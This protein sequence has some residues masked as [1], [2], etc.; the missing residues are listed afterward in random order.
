M[1]SQQRSAIRERKEPQKNTRSFSFKRRKT[2]NK[3]LFPIHSDAASAASLASSMA[4]CRDDCRVVEKLGAVQ[5]SPGLVVGNA[6]VCPRIQQELQAL[7]E[8]MVSGRHARGD[9]VA[10][11]GLVDI[12]SSGSESCHSCSKALAAGEYELGGDAGSG[13]VHVAASGNQSRH[14]PTWTAKSRAL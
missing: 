12:G 1:I 11:S 7:W 9:P 3:S 13:A 5:C 14:W 2:T 6:R 4:I 10:R 8:A